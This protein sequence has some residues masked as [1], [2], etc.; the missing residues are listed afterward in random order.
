[1]NPLIL[2][3][4][5]GGTE[6]INADFADHWTVPNGHFY[7]VCDGINH[8]NDTATAVAEF[9]DFLKHEL[10]LDIH[11]NETTLSNSIINAVRT[12]EQQKANFAFCMTA[13]LKLQDRVIIMHCGDCRLGILTPKGVEWKTT[14]DVPHYNL[15]CQGIIN[16][17][18]YLKTRHLVSCK[19]KPGANKDNIKIL[20]LDNPE[21]H[22]MLLCSDGFWSHIEF[23]L[24]G[25]PDF[26]V[27]TIEEMLLNLTSSAPDN[28]SLILV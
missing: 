8:N 6:S 3:C 14:D 5:P 23:E 11:L 10:L 28:F 21:P 22:S 17:D 2:A 26:C 7:I 1:M 13:A 12:L 4:E 20:S 18:T 19:I 9:C 27:K 25:T 15:Y 24:T 16:K